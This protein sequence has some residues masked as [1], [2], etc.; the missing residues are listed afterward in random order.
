MLRFADFL[1]A[2]T[3]PRQTVR[4]IGAFLRD[5]ASFL[6]A[7]HALRRYNAIQKPIEL[8]DYIRFLKRQNISNVME[9]GTRWGGTLATHCRLAKLDGTVVSLD[10]HPHED[11]AEKRARL[12]HVACGNQNL[13]FVWGNSHAPESLAAVEQILQGQKLDLLF[14][15]GDHT[16]DGVKQDFQMYRHLV[17]D[18]GV[19]AFH[20]IADCI[21]DPE[22]GVPRFWNEIKSSYPHE[23]F[24]D[25][26]H[27]ADSMG[28][29]VLLYK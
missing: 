10:W 17:R 14:I 3:R 19:I 18:G 8:Y 25:P 11:G 23:E 6:L 12:S 4:L 1:T 27:P 20:D 13:H 15:D 16:Y 24:L 28:I 29:S 2:F 22:V 9:I 5:R 26:T 7:L 21:T